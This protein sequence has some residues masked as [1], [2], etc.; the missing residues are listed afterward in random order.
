MQSPAPKTNWL[1]IVVTSLATIMVVAIGVVWYAHRQPVSSHQPIKGNS[2]TLIYHESGCLS[3]NNI[4][5]DNIVWFNTEE[6]AEDA[7]YRKAYNC[8]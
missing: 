3:Y 7:G 6:E 8:P 4:S 5:P 2:K 1:L